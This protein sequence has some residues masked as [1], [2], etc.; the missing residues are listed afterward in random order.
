MAAMI[1]AK[2]YKPFR[3]SLTVLGV[4]IPLFGILGYILEFGFTTPNKVQSGWFAGMLAG[5]VL[6][7][8]TMLAC[9]IALGLYG[10]KHQRK[11]PYLL[12]ATTV[13]AVSLIIMGVAIIATKLSTLSNDSLLIFGLILLL[14]GLGAN[15]LLLGIIANKVAFFGEKET[16]PIINAQPVTVPSNANK[17]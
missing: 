10:T 12:S 7:A 14:S 17:T 8:G 1:E 5:L 15:Y 3:Y 13:I 16:A 6:F 11:H 4:S 9:F 2:M